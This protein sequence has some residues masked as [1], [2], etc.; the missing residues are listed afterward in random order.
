MAGHFIAGLVVPSGMVRPHPN[1]SSMPRPALAAI[2]VTSHVLSLALWLAGLLMAGVSAAIVFPT[3]KSLAPRLPAYEQYVGD[4]W[5]IAAGH[6]Q[7]RIFL[8]CDAGQLI[9]G[10]IA[11]LTLGLMLIGVGVPR[12]ERRA[13]TTLRVLATAGALVVL[14]FYLIVLSPRMQRNLTAYWSNAE[15]GRQ[16]EAEVAQAAFETDHPTA[17]RAMSAIAACVAVSLVASVWCLAMP[18]TARREVAR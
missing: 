2:V 13:S 17:S 10:G 5:K 8:V 1:S 11:F 9:F 15:G 6:V 14:C 3:T 7:Q 16:A 4:H 12:L 18:T